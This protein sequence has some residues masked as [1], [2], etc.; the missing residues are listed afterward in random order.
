MTIQN[1]D[2]VTKEVAERMAALM[3]WQFSEFS[4]Y[5]ISYQVCRFC[6]RGA[7][8]CEG[9]WKYGVRHWVCT[10]CRDAITRRKAVR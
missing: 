7:G 6:H 2:R 10:E 3:P 4:K 9:L 5:G 1:I 8:E